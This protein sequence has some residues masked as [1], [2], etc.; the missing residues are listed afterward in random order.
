ML[1]PVIGAAGND[2]DIIYLG[3]NT[4][5][6]IALICEDGSISPIAF[7]DSIK[8]Q[9]D[10][11]YH[12]SK[13]AYANELP[14]V[15]RCCQI[16]G[17]LA[18]M[19]SPEGAAKLCQSCFPLNSNTVIEMLGEGRSICASTADGMINLA[20]RRDVRAFCCLPPLVLGPNDHTDSDVVNRA[21]S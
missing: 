1:T 20:M 3:Y 14:L 13:C 8:T 21:K 17:T 19:V 16:W 10:F 2:W 18:Y 4:D 9:S 5:A 6:T 11:F 7:G 15:A 12:Y